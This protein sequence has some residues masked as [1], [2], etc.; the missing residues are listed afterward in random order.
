M[1]GRAVISLFSLFIDPPLPLYYLEGDIEMLVSQFPP[2]ST[3]DTAPQKPLGAIVFCSNFEGSIFTIC[4]YHVLLS[5]Y[6]YLTNFTG[7]L[8]DKFYWSNGTFTLFF[9]WGLRRLDCGYTKQYSYI[10]NFQGM[11]VLR[12]KSELK[13]WILTS[14]CLSFIIHVQRTVILSTVQGLI[15]PF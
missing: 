9:C 14:I 2:H 7:F 5:C 10:W 8:L 1:T 13:L 15:F 12:N 3:L 6:F 11:D 4:N